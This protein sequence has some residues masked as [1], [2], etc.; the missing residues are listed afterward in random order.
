MNYLR[1]TLT[2][3]AGAV[4]LALSVALVAP[5]LIDW[6]S[7]RAWIESTLSAAVGGQVRIAGDIDVRLL[8][9][10][11]L[12]LRQ[13][14]W[15]AGG[16]GAPKVETERLR[17]EV[18]VAPLLQ[19]A[20]RFVEARFERPRV[21]VALDADGLV[22]LPATG[23]APAAI[24]FERFEARGA[25]IEISHGGGDPFVLEDVS[26][27]ADAASLRGPFRGAGRFAHAG[28]S[29]SYRFA[30]SVGDDGR[31]RA[32]AT[33]DP[34]GG[35]PTAEFDGVV[36]ADRAG[37]GVRLRLEG[38]AVVAGVAAAS[39]LEAP[40]R[41]SG[42]LTAD[43]SAV[44]L[45]PLDV[46]IGPSERPVSAAGA[47]AF[48]PA[49]A[50]VSLRLAASQ[51]DL[52][53]LFPGEGSALARLGGA[54]VGAVDGPARGRA[55]GVDLDVTTPALQL[56]GETLTD[57][58]LRLQAPPARGP[59]R[60]AL[61]SNLPGRASVR[62]D[63]ELETGL[64]ARFVGRA[65]AGVRDFPRLAD[66]LAPAAP[67]F[68][69]RLRAL[70]FRTLEAGADAA[71]SRPSFSA[72]NL[73]LRIDRSTF[74]GSLGAS[75]AVA[76]EPARVFADLTSPALDLD[77]LPDLRGP[78]SALRDVDLNLSLDA[79]A[80]RLARV[81]LAMVDSGRIRVRATR[82]KGVLD[83]ERLSVENLGGASLTAEG[84]F[85]PSGAQVRGRLEA[86][87]LV[88]L[89][90]LLRRVAPGPAADLFAERAVALSP[91][92][93]E[94]SAETDAASDA[95][96]VR[97]VR[98]DGVA[99][100]T[101]LVGSVRPLGE[102]VQLE[103]DA[104]S[105]DT[106]IFLRQ[107]GIEGAPV[108][109]LPRSRLKVSA[110]GGVAQGFDAEADADIAGAAIGY[111]G[112]LTLGAD[113][114]A[115]RGQGR[116]ASRDFAPLLQALAMGW[117][118]AQR[119]LPGEIRGDVAWTPRAFEA[120]A[121]AG[122]LAGARLGGEARFAPQTDGSRRTLTGA[123][124][125]DRI[126]LD[127]LLA[128]ALGP[129][130]SAPGA[131]VW[132]DAAFA[133]G[134][135]G[136]P[137]MALDLRVGVVELRAGREAR[138]AI[139]R[140]EMSP[141]VVVLDQLSARV[142]GLGLTGRLSARRDK[143]DASLAARLALE[144]P[145]DLPDRAA[146]RLNLLVELA[147]SGRS[148][149]GLIANLA[150]SGEARIAALAAPR[151]DPQALDRVVAAIERDATPAEERVALAAFARELE[152]SG[153]FVD[154]ARFDILTAGGVARLQPTKLASAHADVT[155][156]ATIDLRSGALEHAL[157]I[158]SLKPPPRWTG[159]APRIRI[160]ASGPL[161]K[162]QR[163][164]E[165]AALLNALSARAIA[166]ETARIE[167]LE[168]D[169][170][171]RAFFNRR[172]RMDQWVRQRERE[173]AA[174]RAERERQEQIEQE[175]RERLERLAREAEQRALEAQRLQEAISP[176]PATI[177]PPLQLPSAGLPFQLPS[178][179]APLSPPPPP[180]APR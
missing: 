101:R 12:D 58:S 89:S 144:G 92:R 112:R 109:G 115:A 16:I 124:A 36:V 63:G 11:R 141:G 57:A 90:D 132:S 97:A 170:R 138:D 102:G 67:D 46:R 88:E 80:V 64:A 4:L 68:A 147:S 71:I 76:G 2:I 121:L 14:S 75:A 13:A 30:A 50:V 6:R 163:G 28:A 32:K 117:P 8:P 125:L 79:R 156:S 173:I 179:S 126:A 91:A 93:I 107:L 160:V 171:E 20:V 177:P 134:M 146:G 15:S 165:A 51:L 37:D 167:A 178:A 110:R 95:G 129:A 98:I 7:H 153:L 100:G 135:P 55:F 53:R 119:A 136:V 85:A 150:G 108:P 139:L 42:A 127:T 161:D 128:P 52:D 48:D 65:E 152:R 140:F 5:L 162:P 39:G 164:I 72:R 142:G 61:S 24:A 23:P 66:W 77:G 99:R 1:E 104:E 33:A 106:P 19:G 38:S 122:V 54:V 133:P 143:V 114:L 148:E 157:D 94:L 29:G 96:G 78:A 22:A 17:L 21:I 44:R 70:P 130:L 40:Y 168:A 18:A 154:D 116:L 10:P 175:R 25:R 151:V 34:G 159:E 149:R 74:A 131:S 123:L 83:L 172:Q 45:D 9:A 105:A 169:I 137:P 3:L 120:R 81:G 73:D 87:R 180:P 82:T 84:R 27:D 47:L 174:F 103:V 56:G 43:A 155:A 166:R 145:L 35:R 118:D 86:Q 26:L 176:P 113:G 111:T 59:V 31:L 60:L 49:S 41:I 69:E 62:L 158:R